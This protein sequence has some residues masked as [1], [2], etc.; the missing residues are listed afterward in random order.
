MAH[1]DNPDFLSASTIKGDKVVNRE[2]DQI[3]KIEELMLDLQAGRIG[4]A[5][6]SFGGFLGMGDKLFAIPWNGF[7][8]KLHDHAFLL[9]IDKEVLER[10]EGFDRDR[11]P[12]N[13]RHWVSSMYL[14][15]GY[16]P[17]WQTEVQREESEEVESRAGDMA[18]RD[19]PEFLSAGTI[20]G[21]KVVNRD[22]DHIGR[23]KELMLDLQDGNV[24]YAV[25]LHG[26][27]L[28]IGIKLFAIPWQALSLRVHEHAFILDIPEET[29]EKAESFD[30]NRW[31]LTREELSA[32]YTYYGYRP[33]W[34][35]EVTEPA[36]ISTGA[37]SEKES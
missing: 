13:D 33:Y 8:L 1:K 22:G 31:P 37:Q 12:I 24:A 11:W 34:Q 9:D 20:T 3:G 27:V 26:G 14:Y 10:A 32:T 17:Y 4:Y 7:K 5:V 30:K 28:G 2:G 23:I 18:A 35:R 25:I 19:N 16:Q 15:Y 36:G 29:F 21:D 6:L